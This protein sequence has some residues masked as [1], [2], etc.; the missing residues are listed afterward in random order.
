MSAPIVPNSTPS[1]AGTG[2]GEKAHERTVETEEQ[3]TKNEKRKQL[4]Q[5][6]TEE[7]ADDSTLYAPK[8]TNEDRY[9]YFTE[10]IKYKP[11]PK[12]PKA[13]D[14]WIK[15]DDVDSQQLEERSFEKNHVSY[16]VSV[17]SNKWDY[18][19]CCWLLL[20]TILQVAAY[21]DL[22]AK[23]GLSTAIPPSVVD[24]LD[25]QL[26][27]LPLLFIF[28]GQMYVVLSTAFMVHYRNDLFKCFAR[29]SV[30]S[31]TGPFENW[32]MN[33]V[34]T[35][36]FIE[37][38]YY[39][40]QNKTYLAGQVKREVTQDQLDEED[41]EEYEK[42][43]WDPLVYPFQ[44]CA[45]CLGR[46]YGYLRGP[47]AVHPVM[48]GGKKRNRD[49]DKEGD[50][51]TASQ[52]SA[53]EFGS[54]GMLE[55]SSSVEQMDRI[56]EEGEEGGDGGDDGEGD[57]AGEEGSTHGTLEDSQEAEDSQVTGSELPLSSTELSKKGSS[58]VDFSSSGISGLISKSE[59]DGGG[60]E[61]DSAEEKDQ[62]SVAEGGGSVFS[63][64]SESLMSQYQLDELAKK[65]ELELEKLRQKAAENALVKEWMEWTCVV[66][67][68]ENKE[69]AHPVKL[70]TMS[71]GEKGVF[72]KRTYAIIV[73]E[74]DM[75]RCSHCMTYADYVPP[76]GTA[77]LFPHND[78]PH[79]A[80]EDFPPLPEHQSGLSLYPAHRWWNAIR[81]AI[82]GLRDSHDSHLLFPD[83]RTP[84]W[85]TSQFPVIPRQCKAP[86]DLFERGE[87]VECKLQRS[88]WCRAKLVVAHNS[89]AYD[90]LYENGVQLRFVAEEHLRCLPEKRAY[91]YAV[92]LGMVVLTL[93][94]PLS[95]AGI[96]IPT[97]QGFSGLFLIIP[98]S[99]LLLMVTVKRAVLI[100]KH[101]KAGLLKL[102]S[103]YLVYATPLIL[104]LVDGVLIETGASYSTSATLFFIALMS[105][106]PALYTMK[107]Y[108]ASF[109]L[110]LFVQLCVGLLLV[111]SELDGSPMLSHQMAVNCVPI[112]TALL[113]A[114]FYRW[115][116]A[117][118]W[119]VQMK[120]RP[121]QSLLEAELHGGVETIWHKIYRT[122][123]EFMAQETFLATCWDKISDFCCAFG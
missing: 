102:L 64:G 57:T 37:Y 105:S 53:S 8:L 109:G 41:E 52:I 74:R 34:L 4:L 31:V 81:S 32:C 7:Y 97:F 62:Q 54:Q 35:G 85:I 17:V 56:A 2:A 101:Y 71:F 108:Y 98:S 115:S 104:L 67:G 84:L 14:S 58:A 69:N 43:C 89:H 11:R 10:L 3:K 119:D 91:A 20:F 36:Q 60:G 5:M 79:A 82:F 21:D 55:G 111:A 13:F 112:W 68:R 66:C 28:L 50:I 25:P 42:N 76:P 86:M 44:L 45:F 6:R 22:W 47:P 26:Y 29:S 100:H 48:S 40:G 19:Y 87:T 33:A 24:A 77:H 18:A 12:P 72:Y 106:L 113:T 88:D 80:F 114:I 96:F 110:L 107:P 93:I 59:A 118:I 70:P 121:L 75:P 63:K 116:L 61:G 51:E 46:C 92:E 1:R 94:F 95:L 30:L 15:T 90:I 27:C 16:L 65:K 122:Y 78:D 38:M 83:W 39:G 49:K 9:N 120:I 123:Q 23:M 103:L 99:V 73:R 117:K